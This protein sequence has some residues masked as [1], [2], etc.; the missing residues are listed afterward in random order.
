MSVARRL[1]AALAVV[2]AGV[3]AY[4]VPA[5]ATGSDSTA[6][7]TACIANPTAGDL[8]VVAF[9]PLKGTARV[10]AADGK[11]VCAEVLLS[12]YRVPDD[13]DGTGFNETAVP[14][15]L[16]ATDAGRIE[17][18]R[19]TRL[20]VPVPKCGNLQIDLYFPPEITT[21][22]SKGHKGQFIAGSIWTTVKKN[23]KP[24]PCTP[25][26]TPT[27]TTPVPTP[28]ETTPVPTP[29]ET[30]PVPTP[31]ETTPVPTPTETTPVPTPTETTPVPTTAPPTGGLGAPIPVVPPQAPPA[32]PAL[33]ETGS[34]GTV[35]LLGLGIALLG[36]G[37]GLSL[38][39]R[40]RTA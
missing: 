38:L 15:T 34:S 7:D 17:G 11:R 39:G 1:A 10:R 13:W 40:R 18:E 12:I 20:S 16:L 14:Q 4:A 29:T 2:G 31:T 33:A 26:P 3:L 9:N 19:T 30:T 21:V 25:V 23:G 37:V 32:P 35:P 27:E 24:K 22:T 5:S 28:T 6:G 8:Q 36:A